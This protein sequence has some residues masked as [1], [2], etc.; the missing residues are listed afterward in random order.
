MLRFRYSITALILIFAGGGLAHAVA[1]G[2]APFFSTEIRALIEPCPV[3]L[4]KDAL[5]LESLASDQA[6]AERLRERLES[7][8]VMQRFERAPKIAIALFLATLT[9]NG[10]LVPSR[11]Q[12]APLLGVPDSTLELE[13]VAGESLFATATA[14]VGE[15]F[16]QTARGTM[17]FL[18]ASFLS[19]GDQSYLVFHL[20][21]EL[22]MGEVV[23]AS[24][25]RATNYLRDGLMTRELVDA[26]LAYDVA[27]K[28]QDPSLSDYSRVEVAALRRLLR[29]RQEIQELL[30]SLPLR[31]AFSAPLGA[32]RVRAGYRFVREE[33]N[34][35]QQIQVTRLKDRFEWT[36]GEFLNAT[37][38]MDFGVEASVR[39]LWHVQTN[40]SIKD[41]QEALA[42]VSPFFPM[43]RP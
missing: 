30:D 17:R 25:Q 5:N 4:M 1:P 14:A 8:A 38:V 7:S 21:A 15:S 19:K 35:R 16:E 9:P 13:S 41:V 31:P 12:A 39:R 23:S 3:I 29:E 6:S 42:A 43:R 10:Q 27:E 37:G 20:A 24:V 18:G 33:R 32:A 40:G 34:G 26:A 11:A 22:E 28:K 36:I 2:V